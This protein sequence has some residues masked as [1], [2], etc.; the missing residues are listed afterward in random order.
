MNASQT[1]SDQDALSTHVAA[2]NGA[3][4]VSIDAGR[5]H[6][7]YAD[8][9]PTSSTIELSIDVATGNPSPRLRSRLIDA[10]F[11]LDVMHTPA[12]LLATLPLG[13]VDLLDGVAQH[14]ADIA[15]RAAGGSCLVDGHLLG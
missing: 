9:R 14:C 15:I 1:D 5:Y 2:D 6:I 8:I 7:A 4:H 3:Y 12:T 13:D 10:V 11:D